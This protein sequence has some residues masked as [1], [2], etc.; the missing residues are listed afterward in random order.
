MG[1]PGLLGLWW[2]GLFMGLLLGP[3]TVCVQGVMGVEGPGGEGRGH[4]SWLCS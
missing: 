4:Q 2:W 1:W 3:V